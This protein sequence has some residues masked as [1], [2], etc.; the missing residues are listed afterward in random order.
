LKK[1]LISFTIYHFI[2]KGSTNMGPMSF[3]RY[4]SK[5]HIEI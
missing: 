3:E 2:Y 4:D 1:D 5:L